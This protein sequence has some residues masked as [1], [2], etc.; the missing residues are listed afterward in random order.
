MS[1]IPFNVFS[2]RQ[3]DIFKISRAAT[4]MGLAT[5]AVVMP[6]EQ[7]PFATDLGLDGKAKAATAQPLKNLPAGSTVTIH[8]QNYTLL[9][10]N[11]GYVMRMSS[12]SDNGQFDGNSGYFSVIDSDNIGYYLNNTF[13]NSLPPDIQN[14]IRTHD[15]G[16]YS[17]DT[18]KIGLLSSTEFNQYRSYI[19][20]PY[21]FWLRDPDSVG[22]K[23]AKLY[24]PPSNQISYLNVYNAGPEIRPTFYI[25]PNGMVENGVY[26]TNSTPTQLADIPPQT[27]NVGQTKT[28]DLSSHFSDPDGDSLSYSV[29]NTNPEVATASV[30]GITLTINAKS[31]GSTNI[32]VIANDGKGGSFGDSF[33]LNVAI[34]GSLKDLP[35]G[36]II[37]FAGYEWIVLDPTT[38][39]M[40]MKGT[41][42][43]LAFDQNNS[44]SFNPN[45]MS[46]IGY[47]LNNTFYNSLPA[48]QRALIQTKN[49]TTGSETN[50][51][52]SSVSAKIGLLSYSEWQKY[53][54]KYGGSAGFLDNPSSWVW[55]RTPAG[56][57]VWVPSSD[58]VLRMAGAYDTGG[59]VR[60]ALYLDP[61]TSISNGTVVANSAPTATDIPTQTVF[62]GQSRT[63]DMS[64]YFSDSDGDTLGYSVSSSN[65]GVASPYSISGNT[66]TIKGTSAGSTTFTAL[67]QDGKGGKVSKTFTVNVLAGTQS[68]KDLPAGSVIN[69]AGYSWVILVPSKGYLMMKGSLSPDRAFDPTSNTVYSPSDTD[70]IARY[71]NI[72]WLNS[73]Q[74]AQS[75]MIQT[76]MWTIGYEGDEG[77]AIVSAKVGLISHS[78]WLQ[79]KNIY[80]PPGKLTWTRTTYGDKLNVWRVN[81]DGSLGAGNATGSIAVVPTVYL[82]PNASISNGTVVAN[83]VPTVT[84]IPNQTGFVGKSMT[85]DMSNYFSDADGDTLSYTVSS[86]STGVATASMSGNT[87]TLNGVAQGNSTITVTASDGKGGQV[88]KSF[89]FNVDYLPVAIKDMQAGSTIIMGGYEWIVLNPSEGYIISKSAVDNRTYRSSGVEF[90][91]SDGVGYYLNTTFYNSYLA[92]YSSV[93][94]TKTW[95]IGNIYDEYSKT[96]TAKVAL[97]GSNEFAK[98]SQYITPAGYSW[99]RS[100]SADRSTLINVFDENGINYESGSYPTSQ[101]RNAM[102]TLY[103]NPSTKI[104]NGDVQNEVLPGNSAPIIALTNDKPQM[105]NGTKYIEIKGNVSDANGND[106]TVSATINGKL[107]SQTV[108]GG[109]GPFTLQWNANNIADGVYKDIVITA[110]DGNGGTKTTTFTN[111]ITVDKTPPNAPTFVQDITEVTAKDVQVDVS[112]SSDSS[113]KEYKVGEGNWQTYTGPITVK[114]NTTFSARAYDAAGNLIEVNHDVTNIDDM[115][116]INNQPDNLTMEDMSDANLDPVNII[117]ANLPVYKSSFKTYKTDLAR[118]L[119]KDDARKII[120]SV[121][122][123]IYAESNV[124]VTSIRDA[125]SKVNQLQ[126]GSLKDV[127]MSRLSKLVKA[128]D[129]LRKGPVTNNS[130]TLQWD[131][132]FEGATYIVERDGQKVYEG[133]EL[134]FTDDGLSTN[135]EYKYTIKTVVDTLQSPTAQ[136]LI[137]TL[138]NKPGTIS[139]SEL[140]HDSFRVSWL[141]NGNPTGTEYRTVVKEGNFQRTDSGWVKALSGK[142]INLKPNTQY[143]VEIKARNLLG[144]ETELSTFSIKTASYGVEAVT[145]LQMIK[146][147]GK[148]VEL[149]WE[150]GQ[151]DTEFLIEKYRGSTKL[152]TFVAQEKTFV[153]TEVST[154]AD[155]TYKIIARN[156]KYGYL[157]EEKTVSANIPYPSAPVA[158]QNLK[159]E[160]VTTNSFTA[161]WDASETTK[162]YYVELLEGSTRKVF[163]STNALSMPFT[164]LKENTEYTVK[165]Y[166]MDSYGQYSEVSSIKQTTKA[167]AAPQ[168][169]SDFETEIEGNNVTISWQPVEGARGYYVARYENGVRKLYQFVTSGTSY[170]E[171]NVPNGEHEYQVTVY[172]QTGMLE[173]VKKNVVLGSE[174]SP[175]PTKVQNLKATVNGTNVNLTWNALSGNVYGYYIERWKDGQRQSR[176]LINSHSYIDS[177]LPNGDYE[178]RVIGY[179]DAGELEAAVAT[180]KIT[181]NTS[182][183]SVEPVKNL[184]SVVTGSSVQL[185][186]DQAASGAYGYYVERYDSKGIRQYRKLVTTNGYADSS[187][188]SGNYTYKVTVYHKDGET[189]PVSQT[190]TVGNET[191]L[192][193]IQEVTANVEGNQ[194]SLNWDNIEN[195]YGYF[196]ERWKGS[197]KEF[198]KLVTSNAYVDS[199]VKD[200]AYTYKIVVYSKEGYAS[201]VAKEVT[202]GSTSPELPTEPPSVETKVSNLTASVESSKVTLGWTGVSNA[203]GYYVERWKGTKKESSQLVT[204][205]QYVDQNVAAGDYT[206]KVL[207]YNKDGILEPVTKDVTV[208]S[209]QQPPV[210]ETPQVGTIEDVTSKVEGNKV[211][212]NWNQVDHAYGFYVERWNGS[213]KEFSKLVT[214]NLYVD[215]NVANGD[216]TYKVIVYSKDGNQEPV[217]ETVKVGNSTTP[218]EP[219]QTG[220]TS[221]TDL[222]STISGKDV[223]LNWNQV[224]GAYGYYVERWKGGSRELSKLV[225]TT[226]Y[227]DSNVADGQ[228]TYKVIVYQKGG[229]QSPVEESV[230][231]GSG[232][233]TPSPGET[234]PVTSIS[235][236]TS[237]VE[238]DKVTLNWNKVDGAYGYYIE[239]WKDGVRAYSK[240]VTT[241]SYIDSNVTDGDYVY[242]V[243]VYQKGGNLPP[244]EEAIKVGTTTSPAPTEPSETT[245][246]IGRIE[247]V[248]SATEG[249]KVTLVW[250]PV[251]DVYG[252]FVERWKG[253]IKEFS[254]LVTEAKFEDQSVP[255][256]QYEYKVITYSKNGMG[257]PVSEQVTM[258]QTPSAPTIPEESSNGGSSEETQPSNPVQL[259]ETVTTIVPTVEG[260]TVQLDWN[261]V[262]QVY[263][264]YVEKWQNGVKKTR[265][266]VTKSEFDEQNVANGTY[267]YRIIV[268]SQKTRSF[269]EPVSTNVIV[270]S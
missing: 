203:Y 121:N 112:F 3:H 267:E 41:T 137:T 45:N 235:D 238:G 62:V 255:D 185:T 26:K 144:Q 143:T 215:S 73:L 82:D 202:V 186:W 64:N 168:N 46:N 53:S 52:A 163:K 61:Q 111:N 85:L 108:S 63:L 22:N 176:Q 212:L 204:T 12:Y 130:A 43:Q 15:W 77:S 97:I 206:Y 257:E 198:S 87:L 99:T 10:P 253:S 177:S 83:S 1:P 208:E 170:V 262:D 148:Q 55:T 60:P 160:E 107:V 75:N 69:F 172:H 42:G 246:V 59:T 194:V 37:N 102:P 167:L 181:A 134:T 165:V 233:T 125:F 28:I 133:N 207:V 38:G 156:T 214:S 244:V 94:Q 123:V 36:T 126:T 71:L 8:G 142:A 164:N 7:I 234:P 33:S 14:A 261:D 152:K 136:Y 66:L 70:N 245:P 239:R 153:D 100:I 78:E 51:S 252:Y 65:S 192:G 162:M 209:A 74:S 47:T 67:A 44:S 243:I 91:L 93:I 5:A 80:G 201:P 34:S 116:K 197:T 149:T 256:G 4:M 27:A 211:T 68:I 188:P 158:P 11:T 175:A 19:D 58:G 115:W 199:N 24:D 251:S 21:R 84:T 131:A 95:G 88:S 40:W 92:P 132:V 247:D 189:A 35:A 266:F 16:A 224:T 248:T 23:Y 90:S 269:L 218:T 219:P 193:T 104:I 222:T 155:Y 118:N 187:V 110:N 150:H 135:A 25:D 237:K 263:G 240:L 250:N 147:D 124:N 265:Q 195:I 50:E 190:V 17:Y 109:N 249:T 264:Y 182:A 178:Y 231:I 213:S 174:T 166:G 183:P 196:V 114:E 139:V 32:S 18:G 101:S 232:T 200:G 217:L 191:Q 72:D 173:P 223:T 268:Y 98:Y 216:Y 154:G 210:E 120:E 161:K 270:G 31:A 79:Y 117:E 229:N 179:T 205:T 259:A 242:K 20:A 48:E 221:I 226:S 89:T 169:L 96:V 81:S 258:G 76:K 146:N 30:S 119:V 56:S 227:K 86:S 122:G 29:S 151:G 103:L 129:R 57:R 228:Y 236:V 9:D 159:A 128:P 39:Y 220:E 54:K 13:Y 145:N 241:N 105:V 49:W 157:S 225:T 113:I 138:A 127:L 141:A 230:T 184:K 260:Q 254:K 6:L 180:A 106:V 140:A 2:K 171:S